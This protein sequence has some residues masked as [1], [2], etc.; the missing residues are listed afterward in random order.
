V[1]GVKGERIKSV[2]GE[3]IKGIKGERCKGR[4][5]TYYTNENKHDVIGA[6]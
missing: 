3:R 5:V 4:G 2:K 1:K 6:S